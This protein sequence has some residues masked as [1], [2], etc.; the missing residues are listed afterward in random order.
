MTRPG[1][2][3]AHLDYASA[4]EVLLIPGVLTFC[5]IWAKDQATGPI[6]VSDPAEIF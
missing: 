5:D 3:R 2:K 6:S 4:F 1:G